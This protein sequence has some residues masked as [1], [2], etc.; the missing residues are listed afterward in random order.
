MEVSKM[1]EQF[2]FY[3]NDRTVV[4][5]L[6][7]I[8]IGKVTVWQGQTSD[9]HFEFHTQHEA[10]WPCYLR[11]PDGPKRNLPKL[12]LKEGAWTG[13]LLQETSVRNE[14]KSQE[15]KNV[16][17]NN[18]DAF[19]KMAKHYYEGVEVV[20]TAAT[21][22]YAKFTCTTFKHAKPVFVRLPERGQIIGEIFWSNM[23]GIAR[24]PKCPV[25]KGST[26]LDR[27][28][29][30]Q[31]QTQDAIKHPLKYDDNFEIS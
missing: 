21:A 8:E 29:A 28:V 3:R 31:L 4:A 5:A 9:F 1:P 14:R 17:T 16:I 22:W 30:V 15:F 19:R 27:G 7:A 24:K 12:N 11:E 23:Q 2:H 6:T 20:S 26:C 10:G 18:L 25:H 13:K